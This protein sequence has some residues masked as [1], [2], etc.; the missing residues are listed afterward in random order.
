MS[1][2]LGRHPLGQWSAHCLV[3]FRLLV[4]CSVPRGSSAWWLLLEWKAGGCSGG[5]L[6]GYCDGHVASAEQVIGDSS[7]W[8][9]RKSCCPGCS[10]GVLLMDCPSVPYREMRGWGLWEGGHPHWSMVTSSSVTF[11][12]SVALGLS[13]WITAKHGCNLAESEASSC[14]PWSGPR[15]GGPTQSCS[16]LRSLV[17]FFFFQR[18]FRKSEDGEARWR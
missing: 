10:N 11:G 13:P 2:G 8:L 12:N 18:R 16:P 17:L 3:Q 1:A 6:S 4:A 7:P 15:A 14:F 5:C 9:C